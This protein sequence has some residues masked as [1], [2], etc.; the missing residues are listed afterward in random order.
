M[1]IATNAVLAAIL[2]EVGAA[3][4]PLDLPFET[5]LVPSKVTRFHV[6]PV[7]RRSGTGLSGVLFYQGGYRFTFGHGIIE[8]FNTPKTYTRIQDP[9][10]MDRFA[11]RVRYTEAEC[12]AKFKETMRALGHTNLAILDRPPR[13][14]GPVKFE[15]NVIP[16]YV[17]KWPDP[18]GKLQAWMHVVEAEVNAEKLRVEAF[19]LISPDFRRR[20][21]PIT[22]GQTNV[23]PPAATPPKPLR[24]ELE[25]KEVSQ[26]YAM[27]FIRAILPAVEEFGRKFGPPLNRPVAEEDIVM[28]ES[29]VQ[30]YDQRKPR[31]VWAS[32]RLKSGYQVDYCT[33]RVMA[34]H[35]Q[36]IYSIR[37]G[38]D[39]E[40]LRDTEEYRGPTRFTQEQVVEKVRRLVVDRL[41]LPEKPLFLNTQ[42]VFYYT[43]VGTATN[44]LRRYVFAWKRPETPEQEAERLSRQII[45][46]ISVL[47]E[48]D[49]VSGVIKA[50]S[51]MHPSLDQ[52]DPKIDVP[53]NPPEKPSPGV[54]PPSP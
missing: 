2:L 18:T 22:L 52:P 16:R 48:V 3:V 38:W 6:R 27:A 41:G 26:E 32:L 29:S 24:T 20:P 15:G 12:L 45:P 25:V 40:R 13:V 42:P 10:E 46:E 49:A 53:M 34:V 30:M 1:E 28:G 36:D 8:G 54:S 14:E 50:L 44:T 7:I 5:P 31:R 39:D 4:K 9:S 19:E 35:T 37:G 17:F 51:L 43:A 11:G 47:A 21:W 33:G 23:A